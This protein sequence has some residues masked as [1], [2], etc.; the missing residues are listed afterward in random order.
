MEV[1]LENV[2][3]EIEVMQSADGFTR[4]DSNTSCWTYKKKNHTQ[5][6]CSSSIVVL[7]SG[8]PSLTSDL[9]LSADSCREHLNQIDTSLAQKLHADLALPDIYD[10]DR[11]LLF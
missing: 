7:Q 4:T 8:R 10:I 6:T 2:T 9:C 1:K 11:C 3:A 5:S